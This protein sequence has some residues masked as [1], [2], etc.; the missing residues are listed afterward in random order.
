MQVKSENTMKQIDK[1]YSEFDGI[2]R[3]SYLR[4]ALPSESSDGWVAVSGSLRRRSILRKSAL[5]LG[6]CMPLMA[7]ALFGLRFFNGESEGSENFVAEVHEPS[8]TLDYASLPS[9]SDALIPVADELPHTSALAFAEPMYSSSAEEESDFIPQTPREQEDASKPALETEVSTR[10][11]RGDVSDSGY[12]QVEFL[13]QTPKR[14]RRLI[15]LAASA[16]GLPSSSGRNNAAVSPMLS[17]VPFTSDIR[18]Y[19]ASF[20][21]IYENSDFYHFMPV[22]VSVTASCDLGHNLALSS[23]LSYTMLS[24][25][26]QPRGSGDFARQY[27]HYVGIPLTLDWNFFQRNGWGIYSRVGGRMDVCAGAR[28]DGKRIEEKPLQW[29]LNASVGVNYDFNS[30]VGIFLQPELD[31]YLTETALNTIRSKSP[32]N[33]TLRIGLKFNLN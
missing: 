5:A 32:V 1:D 15:A 22:G 21:E 14:M 16:Q 11:V 6:I 23:G 17:A 18:T 7:G 3:E 25:K 9:H 30:T 31:W 24:S 26:V 12:R 29:T 20:E 2:F 10:P 33:A 28:Y 27:V 8:Q 13:P 19:K 4:E